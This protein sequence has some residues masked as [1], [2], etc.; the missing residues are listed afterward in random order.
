M[1][2][3]QQAIRERRSVRGFQRRDV[4]DAILTEVFT[5][6]QQAPSN[7]NT[8]PWVVH[9]VS[10]EACERLRQR[11]CKA[12]MDPTQHQPDFAYDGRYPGIYRERQH[13]AAAQ[14]YGAMGIARDDKAG[15]GRAML[16]NYAFFGAPHAAFVCLPQPF[17]LREAAD[18]GI[19]LQSLMLAMTAQG[20]ASCPQAALSF[21]APVVRELLGLP[22]ELRILFGLS[23]GY[24]DTE[25]PANQCRVGRADL[26]STV[27]FHR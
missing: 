21:P 19:Y 1:M 16:A 15:R 20:L 7:C 23:F 3:I 9:V 10:G 25:A 5:L 26:A 8:Q 24:E 17:G 18:C 13:D 4:P 27:S 14:L 22:D 2:S 11:L 6:A 12:G